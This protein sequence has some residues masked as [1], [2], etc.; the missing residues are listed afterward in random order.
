M[1]AKKIFLITDFGT[2][3]WY[4]PVM[5]S[6]ILEI[7]PTA[8]IIDGTHNIPSFDRQSASFFVEQVSKDVVKPSI[9]IV[10]VDPGVGGKQ[11]KRVIIENKHWFI[12]PDNGVFSRV[13]TK[14]SKFLEINQQKLKKQMQNY[15]ISDTFHGRD[16]F[17]P[18]AGLISKGVELSEFCNKINTV[19]KNKI[20]IPRWVKKQIIGQIVYIDKFGNLI[21]NI[22]KEKFCEYLTSKSKISCTISGKKNIKLFNTYSQVPEGSSMFIFNSNDY[23][24]IAVNKGDASIFFNLKAGDNIALIVNDV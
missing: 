6:K 7:N 2:Y 10:V 5:K 19:F 1:L 22:N 3:D 24:E 12:G 8:Q 17:A 21:S 13:I 23:L 4:V 20:T 16:I 9:F 11:H 14:G 15:K 18:A